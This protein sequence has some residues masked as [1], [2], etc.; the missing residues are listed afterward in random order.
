MLGRAG[1]MVGRGGVGVFGGTGRRCRDRDERRTGCRRIIRWLLV[2][3][4]H[5]GGRSV[6]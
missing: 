5:C 3:L 6:V 1:L 4:M 2:S